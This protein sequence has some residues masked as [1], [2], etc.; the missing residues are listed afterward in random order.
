MYLQIL[1]IKV[2]T[3]YFHFKKEESV[4]L[5]FLVYLS[6]ANKEKRVVE[7]LTMSVIAMELV[8]ALTLVTKVVTR[9]Q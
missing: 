6:K 8:K 4:A 3:K 5:N 1:I 7:T 9:T 2:I